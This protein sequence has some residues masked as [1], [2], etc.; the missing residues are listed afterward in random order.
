MPDTT[1][2]VEKALVMSPSLREL[3][4]RPRAATADGSG[5]TASRVGR[6]SVDEVG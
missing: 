2:E 3:E 4:R 1:I 6:W 5:E